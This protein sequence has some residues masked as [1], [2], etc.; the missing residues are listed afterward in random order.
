MKV[1]LCQDFGSH[2]FDKELKRKLTQSSF[3]RNRTGK[4]VAYIEEY[5]ELLLKD[6]SGCWF[7]LYDNVYF[8]KEV[9]TSRPWTI[10]DYDGSEYVQYL[11]YNIIDKD[12]NYCKYIN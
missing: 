3:P 9:D 6:T 10:L 2:N 12:L 1:L 11:D 4:A 8:I 7:R 5:G